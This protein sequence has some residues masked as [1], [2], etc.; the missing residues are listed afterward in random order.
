MPTD[1]RALGIR[2]ILVVVV[3]DYIHVSVDLWF[4]YILK[5]SMRYL[6][7]GDVGCQKGGILGY[8]GICYQSEIL[9]NSNWPNEREGGYISGRSS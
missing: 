1:A 9:Q 3:S 8:H 6:L 2:C 4:W 5:K 7:R